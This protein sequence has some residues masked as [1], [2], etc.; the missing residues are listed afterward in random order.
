MLR[1]ADYYSGPSPEA[2]LPRGVTFGCGAA[3]IAGLILLAVGGA[4]MA[5]GGIVDVMDLSFGMSMGQVRGM[6]KSDVTDAQKKEVDTAIEALRENL[7]TGKTPVSA[8]NPVLETMR[9]IMDDKLITAEEARTLI[10]SAHKAAQVRAPTP[11]P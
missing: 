7:R 4:W 2:V 11:K 10:A 8:L 6:Y 9:K 3:S 5:S 1:P